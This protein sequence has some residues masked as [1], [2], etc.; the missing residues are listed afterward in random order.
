M[1]R[2]S[3]SPYLT[4]APHSFFDS[5]ICLACTGTKSG[6]RYGGEEERERTF[7]SVSRP[8]WTIASAISTIG[9]LPENVADV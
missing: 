1:K 8:V 5:I 9:I 2:E 7:S 4:S 6:L 3:V